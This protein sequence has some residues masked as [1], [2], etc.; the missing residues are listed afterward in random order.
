MTGILSWRQWTIG[1]V[2][3][4]WLPLCILGA[5]KQSFTMES[6]QAPSGPLRTAQSALEH[7]NPQEAVR[8]LSS[9]LEAHPENSDAR[10]A[11]GQAYARAGQFDH[12]EVEFQTVLKAAPDN[13]IALTALGELYDRG[14]HSEKAEPLLARAVTASHDN[15]QIRMEW[16][17]V[18]ARLH[19]Y[20][21]AQSALS[22][23]PLPSS[24]GAQIQFHRLKASVALG[25]GNSKTAAVE[26][27]K[28]L[29]LK[30]D[31]EELRLTTAATQVQCSNWKRVEELTRPIFAKA[32]DPSVGMMLLEAQLGANENV[33]PTLE[34]LRKSASNSPDE[35][36]IRQRL[37]ELLVSHEKFKEA[38]DDFQ[39]VVELDPNRADM[40][41]NLALAQFSARRLDD[42]LASAEKCKAL[43]DSADLEDLLGDIQEAR[44][45]NLSAVKS[46]QAAVALAPSQ[47][48]FRLSLA[49]EL[50]RH[51][52]FD[53][54]KA[55]LHQAEELY[56][57]SW[58]VQ[59]ALGMLQYFEGKEEEATPIL[60]RAADL[61]PNPSLALKYVGDIQLDRA[62]GPDPEVASKLCKYADLHVQDA[63]MQYYC[64]AMLFHRDHAAE[65]KAN[66]PEILRRLKSA[67][68]QLPHD[69][70][71]HCELGKAY[72]WLEEWPAALHESEI[73]ARLNPDSA[74]AHYRLAQIYHHEGQEEPAKRERALYEAASKRVADENARR[75]ETM[76]TFLFTIQKEAP[77]HK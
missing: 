27:E 62:A 43:A 67:A 31:D 37:A 48:K 70:S 58:R 49:L 36:A 77:V 29:A 72:R 4:L 7:G 55:V 51:K 1:A 34:A 39:R 18:L 74:E 63:A 25:L 60:L 24:A 46:Y 15:P 66:M 23:L 28:A 73:C 68:N 41:F 2:Y 75:D 65:N 14:G 3:F 21:K 69:A 11:L 20:Q 50:L 64:G 6:Q 32:H 47:E 42:A 57:N 59:F 33:Q 76:K 19:E 53:P 17:L 52:S 13:Y 56:P 26:M 35:P 8:I 10:V 9:Y 40:L 71:P 44:G 22:G 5:A 30:P 38:I 61:S 45:D 12:A 54:A 16:A